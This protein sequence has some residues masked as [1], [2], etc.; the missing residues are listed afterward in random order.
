MKNEANDFINH[1]RFLAF[2]T[3]A[4]MWE[5]WHPLKA[6]D[7]KTNARKNPYFLNLKKSP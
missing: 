7:V 5:N 6:Q 1:S 4:W 3:L 2:L